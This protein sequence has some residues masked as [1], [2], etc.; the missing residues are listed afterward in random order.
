MPRRSRTTRVRPF[1]IFIPPEVAI[2]QGRIKVEIVD[3]T[4]VQDVTDYV[5]GLNVTRLSFDRGM[6]HATV[7]LNNVNGRYLKVDGSLRWNGGEEL[8]IYQDYQTG[9][10]TDSELIFRG[11]IH[12]P[13]RNYNDGLH[14]LTIIG[15]KLPE[16]KDAR[17]SVVFPEGTSFFSAARSILAD[18]PDL[19]D[20][21][22]FDANLG[23]EGGS[24]AAS[25]DDSDSVILN[26]IFLQA[27][28]SG[29]FDNDEDDDG[30]FILVAF[31][32]GTQKNTTVAAV[33]GQTL[34]SILDFGVRTEDVFSRVLVKGSTLG[35]SSILREVIDSSVEADLWRR[36]L[37]VTDNNVTSMDEGNTQASFL[38]G[39]SVLKPEQ[40]ELIMVGHGG[41]NPGE[42]FRVSS[43]DDGIAGFFEVVR[44]EHN[45]GDFFLTTVEISRPLVEDGNTRLLALNDK[46]DALK[47]FDNPNDMKF[48][49]NF[50]FDNTDLFSTSSNVEIADNKVKTTASSGNFTSTVLDTP[51]TVTKVDFSLQGPIDIGSS[52]LFVSA[53]AGGDETELDIGKENIEVPLG[54]PGKQVRVRMVLTGST[55]ELDGVVVRFK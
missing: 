29:Y 24:F 30:K 39:Q 53:D 51:D 48:S 33:H 1:P 52:R 55:V 54:T 31:R 9:T 4:D 6:E 23:T 17:R 32:K 41:L 43:N 37:V 13:L 26:D 36:D 10:L 42:S 49:F 35:G 5:S 18:F 27:G 22:T 15:R 7:I 8:K 45:I 3:G 12:S 50:P 16:L 11:K 34:L 28:W 14:S 40:G 20:L 38:S 19:I 46:V 25:Y 47:T 44:I 2:I 21:T